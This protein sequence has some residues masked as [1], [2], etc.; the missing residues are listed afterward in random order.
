LDRRRFSAIAHG[1]LV[2]WNPLPQAATLALIDSLDV[3]PTGRV[4]DVGCGRAELL[5]RLLARTGASGVGVDPWP[6]AMTLARAA[7]A[8]RVDHFRLELRHESFDPSRFAAASF[9]VALCIGASNAAG[10][11]V[12][13]L[14]AL[15]RLLAPGGTAVVGEGRWLREPDPEYLAFLGAPRDELLD[16]AGNVALAHDE[17]FE[18]VRS[19]VSSNEDFEAYETSYAANV[20]RFVEEHADDPDAAAFRDRIRAWRAAY[21][22]WGR[23]TLG[24][25]LY[26][27]RR[28]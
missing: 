19:L 13:T 1:D 6:H 21:L 26:V 14:R 4:L 5:I 9:D 10:G 8:G 25:A 7:A 22:R 16:H 24:F 15:R 23:D 18:V 27:L 3:P 2:L 28:G 12:E 20:E 11:R 17:G